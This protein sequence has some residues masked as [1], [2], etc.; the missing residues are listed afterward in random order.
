MFG[1]IVVQDKKVITIVVPT[2][3]EEANVKRLYERTHK[4]FSEFLPDYI[5]NIQFI[6]NYSTD[7]TRILIR[8]LC[9]KD[10]TVTAIFNARNFGF[11]RSQFYGLT[12]ATGDAA[13]LMCADMQ[14]PPEIIPKFVAEWENGYKIVAGIK[15]KSKENPLMYLGRKIYYKLIRQ[16]SE[17]EHIDQFDGFGLY[18]RSF[19]DVLRSIND[20]LPY[21]RGI[22]AEL[23]F[24]HKNIYYMQER[25][26][27]GKSHF[28]FLALYDLAMLGITSYSKVV[29]HIVTL[30]GMA[31]S[32]ISILVALFVVIMKLIY[33]STYPFGTAAVQVGVFV[34]GSFQLLTI[35]FV[36]EYIVN[37][38]TR[39][40]HHP[41]VIEETRIN[42]EDSNTNEKEL[43]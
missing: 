36:G 1:G 43:K 40:M 29:M 26:T 3:N 5:C 39:L 23:G 20:P 7:N 2:Y 41:L 10:K 6:D 34:L 31:I 12:Q 42:F 9:E 15:N 30:V 28:H 22:I 27:G 8:E 32:A 18:D 38:N 25:R 13:V 24:R 33:W 19:L 4:I 35:G 17:V 21:L 16:I 11:V 37:M 14:D